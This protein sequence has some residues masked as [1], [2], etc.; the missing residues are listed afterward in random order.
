MILLEFLGIRVFDVVTILEDIWDDTVLDGATLNNSLGGC[1]K[2]FGHLQ[3]QYGNNTVRL[4]TFLQ[5][6]IATWVHRNGSRATVGILRQTFE[7]LN[8]VALSG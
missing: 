1:V 5:T 2:N 4:T 8:C 3:T 7:T 6:I